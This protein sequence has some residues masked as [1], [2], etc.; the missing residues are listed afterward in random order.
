MSDR[1]VFNPDT[2]KAMRLQGNKWVDTPVVVN[3]QNG[4]VRAWDGTNYTTVVKGDTAN[5]VGQVVRKAEMVARGM[6]DNAFDYAEALPKLAERGLDALGLPKTGIRI[7]PREAYRKIGA[8]LSNP[9]QAAL[10]M[11]G[12]DLGPESTTKGDQIAYE[13]GRGMTDALAFM[14]PAA[15]AAKVA[16]GGTTTQKVA[17]QLAAQ[18]VTQTA[19]GLA[20]GTVGEATDNEL[21]GLGAGLL[22]PSLG[23]V[24]QKVISP[25]PL[26][27]RQKELADAAQ[28]EG[29]P[30]TPAKMTDNQGFEYFETL[31]EGIPSTGGR[32]AREIAKTQS[33]F[34]RAVLRRAGINS[35]IATPEVMRKAGDDFGRRF[36]M[37]EAKTTFKPDD[38]FMD[39]LIAVRDNY[40]RYIPSTRKESFDNLLTDATNLMD[41]TQDTG[42]AYQKFASTLRRLSRGAAK[43]GEYQ[44]A[45]NDLVEV[46][47]ETA[48][49]SAGSEALKKSWQKLRREYRAYKI[50]EDSMAKT[51][52]SA[53]EGDISPTAFAGAV[54]RAQSKRQFVSGDGPLEGLARVGTSRVRSSVPNSGTAQRNVIAGLMTGGQAGQGMLGAGGAYM[55]GADPVTGGILGLAL[56]RAVQ[57]LYLSGP[58]RRYLTNQLAANRSRMT[59]ALAAAITT[60]QGRELGDD[61]GL[62]GMGN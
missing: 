52:K 46:V 59:P 3:P 60:A 54:K 17:S 18:P 8:M 30:L 31:L 25:V 33:G 39:G 44:D 32:Q 22:T 34:N 20:A 19:A 42:K 23:R 5:P 45:L 26:Q 7:N 47:D 36:E 11:A 58:G 16:K 13:G 2:Q 28:A 40:A 14:L 29:I 49:R 50:I 61:M 41:F 35:D 62:L 6:T 37:L 9:F 53:A 24:T 51:T 10:E 55:A 12:V 4:E 43:D 57:E 15:T 1:L 27:G 56:P 48:F 21:L 38:Q